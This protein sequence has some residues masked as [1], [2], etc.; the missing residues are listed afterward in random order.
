[1]LASVLLATAAIFHGTPVEI[2]WFAS[3]TQLGSPICGG[4]LIAPDRVLTAAHCVQGAAPGDFDVVIG[5]EDRPW[6][7]AYFPAN[8]RL[9][10]SPVRPDDYSASASIDDIAVIVLT[11]PVT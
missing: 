6:R 4:S 5:G 3:L 10:R 11:A 2:P 7:G 8:Y 9:I 1:M